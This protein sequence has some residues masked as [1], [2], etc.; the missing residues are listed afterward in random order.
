MS[1]V[2]DVAFSKKLFF[3]EVLIR[4]ALQVLASKVPSLAWLA[5]GPL[6]FVWVW[7]GTKI[8][9]F[10]LHETALG[11]SVIYRNFET[12]KDKD[13][14]IQAVKDAEKA[15]KSKILTDEQEA[16]L[17]EAIIEATKRFIRL[18]GMQ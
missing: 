3:A 15:M 14:F 17:E 7:I 5:T 18:R 1:I 13:N 12:E 4:E 11:A 10:V 6:G 16:H 2:G 9:S 8:L